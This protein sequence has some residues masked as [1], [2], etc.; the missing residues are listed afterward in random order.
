MKFISKTL[1]LLPVFLMVLGL[2]GCSD[3]DSYN[4]DQPTAEVTTIVDVA[5]ANNLN[6]LADALRRANLVSTLEGTGPFTVFGPTDE[7]FQNLVDSNEDWNSLD[8]IP[9]SLLTNVL[10]NHVIVGSNFA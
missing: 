1:Q 10:L 7:A 9:L 4:N 6:F 2:T 5:A 3:D 8:D